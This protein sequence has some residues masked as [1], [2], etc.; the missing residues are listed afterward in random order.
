MQPRWSLYLLAFA[1]LPG[2]LARPAVSQEVR[3]PVELFWKLA[4]LAR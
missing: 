3:P 2:L 4:R 1:L